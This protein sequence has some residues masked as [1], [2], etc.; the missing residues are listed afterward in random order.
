MF[1]Q[2]AVTKFP[3]AVGEKLICIHNCLFEV[4]DK[5]TVDMNTR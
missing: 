1:K 5:A 2:Q 3:V 4:Y